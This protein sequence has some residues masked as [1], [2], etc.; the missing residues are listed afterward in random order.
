MERIVTRLIQL[1]L[2]KNNLLHD[3]QHGFRPGRSCI[4]NLLIARESWAQARSRKRDID[5]IYIDFSKAFDKVPH[6]RLINKLSA[7]GIGGG[8]LQWVADFL[9]NRTF[10]VRIE[11]K[12][13]DQHPAD[14]GVPQGSVLGP[15]LFLVFIND[16]LDHIVTPCL[17]YADDIKIL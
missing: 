12:L 17:L 3:G 15:T 7:Y 9:S 13:S 6:K 11:D 2:D 1:H 4:T 16:L 10:R 5:V 14:S 8:T